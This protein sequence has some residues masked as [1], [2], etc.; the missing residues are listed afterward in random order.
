MNTPAT[1]ILLIDSATSVLRVG[2]SSD[3]RNVLFLENA[4]RFKHAEF[5]FTLI[6]QV[7]EQNN[8][9][10]RDLAAIIIT[11]GPG[12][13]TGLRVGMASAKGIAVSL[14]IPLVGVSMYKAI[15]PRLFAEQG[16]TV[17]LIPSRR[18]E[19]YA[20]IIDGESFA[21]EK[22]TVCRS[23]EISE[24][25]RGCQILGIGCEFSGEDFPENS[26]LPADRF[27]LQ[28]ED[29]LKAGLI[30]LEK[31]GGDDLSRLEPLYIQ[32]FRPGKK[33]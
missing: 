17:V 31:N 25:Y 33:S 29:I 15:A 8:V 30:Q 2:M 3:G 13:F 6:E 18:N 27:A 5:V 26:I 21:D 16:K 7:L 11:S 1:H 9:A 14:G 12:S 32:Q 24:I 10:R 19:Y 4:D 22:I 23:S 20:G 28:M